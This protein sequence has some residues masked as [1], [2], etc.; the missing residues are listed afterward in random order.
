MFV[1]WDRVVDN[2]P[3]TVNFLVGLRVCL[4]YHMQRGV[5]LLQ[6][7]VYEVLGVWR[8][9]DKIDH[10][11]ASST[12]VYK[13]L[14]FTSTLL[15]LKTEDW[16]QLNQYFILAKYPVFSQDGIKLQYTCSDIRH[17]C[18]YEKINKKLVLLFFIIKQKK[19]CNVWLPQQILHTA[20]EELL[21]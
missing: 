1:I 11:P 21:P 6:P 20:H 10:A 15:R 7:P 19:F 5:G 3:A 18:D 14:K 16:G 12:E 2:L 9:D 13:V 17:V 4:C 8:P